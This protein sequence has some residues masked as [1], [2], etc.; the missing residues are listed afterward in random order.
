MPI[1]NI[2]PWLALRRK[3]FQLPRVFGEVGQVLLA[4]ALHPCTIIA[5]FLSP[6]DL[7]YQEAI[8]K[9]AKCQQKEPTSGQYLPAARLAKAWVKDNEKQAGN[10]PKEANRNRVLGG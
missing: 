5:D 2:A 9:H 10:G 6:N 1:F 3:Q 7:Q 8:N 4:N